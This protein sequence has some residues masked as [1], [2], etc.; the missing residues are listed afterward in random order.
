VLSK[1]EPEEDVDALVQRSAD[2]VETIVREGLE[3]AQAR[4]N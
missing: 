2:A 4:F 3:T 1:F